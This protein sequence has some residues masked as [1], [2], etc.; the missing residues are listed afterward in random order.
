[1][2]YTLSADCASFRP[3]L[4]SENLLQEWYGSLFLEKSKGCNSKIHSNNLH[5]SCWI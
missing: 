3:E 5:P 1:M 4:W 2:E